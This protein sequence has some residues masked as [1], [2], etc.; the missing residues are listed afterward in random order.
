[1]KSYSMSKSCI[2][3]NHS[4]I[5]FIFL[6][7]AK[8]KLPAT[9]VVIA[10]M[11]TS[12]TTLAIPIMS[13]S[14][15]DGRLLSG[16][17]QSL[18]IFFLMML[19]IVATMSFATGIR[20][21]Y[22]SWLGERIT[23]DLRQ[24]LYTN[25]LHLPQ[26]FHDKSPPAET[27]SRLTTDMSSID[28]VVG[29]VLSVGLRNIVIAIIG[30]VYLFT[31]S[32][33]LA[34]TVLC[35]LPLMIM[36]A[37]FQGK[38]IQKLSV[39]A[40]GQLVAVGARAYEILQSISAVQS[41]GQEDNEDYL[42]SATVDLAFD[43]TILRIKRQSI[44]SAFVIIATFSVCSIILFIALHEISNGQITK[45]EVVSFFFAGAVVA[46]ALSALAEVY[47]TVV[48]SSGG[49][50]RVRELLNKSIT[51]SPQFSAC[52]LPSDKS[53]SIEFEDISFSYDEAAGNNYVLENVSFKVEPSQVVAVVGKSGSGKSTLLDL[54][55][56]FRNPLV[57]KISI[58][59]ENIKDLS[60]R[61]LRSKISIVFQENRFLSTSVRENLTYGR[62]D[63]DD[64]ELWQALHSANASH[65]IQRM[66]LGLDT[67]L[68]GGGSRLSGGER[69][70][71]AIARAILRN[72]GILLLDEATSA[73][74]AENERLVQEGL[75]RLMHDRTVL[76]VAHRLATVHKAD[77]IVVL[78]HGHIVETG[79]HNE[80]VAAGG[81]YSQL[82]ASQFLSTS[83]GQSL[84]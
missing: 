46:E 26:D 48:S 77:L 75:Q 61:E 29:S 66:P 79:K 42:F 55:A 60:L 73:L 28:D 18:T 54:V 35:L 59:N 40:Q 31:I 47:N 20:F 16:N 34:G 57:G 81:L 74:D 14:M 80:L 19:S 52:Y 39:S 8:Y 78:D 2:T 36:A 43:R 24:R 32:T 63:A 49:I 50:K 44:F 23:A 15:I 53:K 11:V 68:V 51:Y 83:S 17:A 7:I 4:D 65:F 64:E 1:M 25:L 82:S 9:I 33:S 3:T 76:I 58:G 41:F 21:Y 6:E 22:V 27:A 13:G 45:G 69:Q 67:H 38:T 62:P 70:R 12:L 71:L 56:G 30:S 84:S 37:S 5:A 72:S 10:L